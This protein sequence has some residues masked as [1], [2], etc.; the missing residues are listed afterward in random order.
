MFIVLSS[1]PK[2]MMLQLDQAEDPRTRALEP[3]LFT[4]GEVWKDLRKGEQ[5]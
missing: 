5:K 3:E 4:S 1:Y 2:W